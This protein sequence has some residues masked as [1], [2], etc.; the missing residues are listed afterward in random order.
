MRVYLPFMSSTKCKRGFCSIL[1][2][3]DPGT[4]HHGVL[5]SIWS[6]APFPASWQME[7]EREV[8]I[9]EVA[10]LILAAPAT[11]SFGIFSILRGVNCIIVQNVYNPTLGCLTLWHPSLEDDCVSSLC[12]THAWPYTH[13]G[14]WKVSG[15]DNCGQAS[16]ALARSQSCVHSYF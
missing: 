5:L 10:I 16:L 15:S 8:H 3:K 12:C 9:Y 4:F 11:G 6:S 1:F 14:Q 13:F 7:K 2:I